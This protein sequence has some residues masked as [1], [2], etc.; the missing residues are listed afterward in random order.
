MGDRTRWKVVERECDPALAGA[1]WEAARARGAVGAVTAGGSGIRHRRTI[2]LY[3]EAARD[4][5]SSLPAE[6]ADF[7]E[8]LAEEDWTACWRDTLVPFRVADRVTIAPAWDETGEG[9]GEI[10]LRI[11]P[12]MAFGAGDHPTTRLCVEFLLDL[13][14]DGAL[15]NPVLDVGA[16]TGVLAL[17]AARLGARRADALDIDPFCY[18]SC[19]RNARRNGLS[20]RVRPLLLS[21]DLLEG[22]Y[23]LALA[24]VVAG[25]LAGLLPL[26][27]E[28]IAAGGRLVLSG[29]Q[30]AD[31]D[32]VRR[33][34]VGFEPAGRREEEGWV[35]LLL[36]AEDR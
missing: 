29:F 18:A 6:E 33:S 14:E 25:Q 32:E 7:A 16:G 9:P 5:S 10:R 2:R 17:A 20:R 13:A 34:A 28:R 36:A 23:P 4:G 8:D 30:S 15:A 21:L 3:W 11:D 19:R 27:R 22:R 26:L 31:E 1:A 35:A 24:N 12:G